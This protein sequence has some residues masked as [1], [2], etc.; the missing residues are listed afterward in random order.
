MMVWKT[1]PVSAAKWGQNSPVLPPLINHYPTFSNTH[2]VSFQS[3]IV[4]FQW[5]PNS[6]WH[7]Q[8]KF[9]KSTSVAMGWLEEGE[10]YLKSDGQGGKCVKKAMWS[11]Q[12]SA[13]ILNKDFFFLILTF[14]CKPT[15]E[16]EPIRNSYKILFSFQLMMLKKHQYITHPY[17]ILKFEVTYC[18]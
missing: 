6:F 10:F 18:S 17:A 8:N 14:R 9:S 12:L 3:Y 16:F 7:E 2:S 11:L 4:R 5:M 15:A 1:S 13:H